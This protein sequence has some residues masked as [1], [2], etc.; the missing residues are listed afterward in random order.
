MNMIDDMYGLYSHASDAHRAGKSAG[1]DEFFTAAQALLGQISVRQEQG[2]PDDQL[3][4]RGFHVAQECA[5][6]LREL[7]EK[8]DGRRRTV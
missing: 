5:K 3:S 2:S 1:R 6:A 4:T 8:F 7:K